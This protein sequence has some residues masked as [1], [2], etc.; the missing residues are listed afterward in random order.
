MSKEWRNIKHNGKQETIVLESSTWQLIDKLTKNNWRT[1]VSKTL[2]IRPKGLANN[3]WLR[4]SLI[5]ECNQIM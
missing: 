2:S 3:H 1:W 5:N 4:N